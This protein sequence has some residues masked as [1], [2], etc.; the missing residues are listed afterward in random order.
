MSSCAVLLPKADVPPPL[1]ESGV[2]AAILIDP[3]AENKRISAMAI[4]PEQARDWLKRFNAL[5]RRVK[6]K[7]V[8]DLSSAIRDGRWKF[9]HSPVVFDWN[10]A[11]M[12]GQNRLLACIRTGTPIVSDVVFG[13]D[14]GLRPTYDATPRSVVDMLA[15]A[16]HVPA[17]SSYYAAVARMLETA[18]REGI[19]GL[20]EPKRYASKQAI[21]AAIEQGR[22]P[23][24]DRAAS[25]AVRA[26][27]IGCAPRVAGFCWYKFAEQ[28]RETA[29]RFIELF[30]TGLLLAETS[31]VLCLRNRIINS[32]LSFKELI[33][34]FFKA[35]IYFRADRSCTK[36][37]WRTQ[38]SN[39]EAF[40]EI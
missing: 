9:N 19:G 18:R 3:M 10:R 11:L 12:D 23:L 5:N 33:A 4:S 21:N 32:K 14:P 24:L 26:R 27:R 20:W 6:A 15:M 7:D 29:D 34:L 13:L 17:N 16:G 30:L 25:V 39:P 37:Y 8:L 22:F 40:P 38:A 31:P 1:P 36:L 35:W 2:E 28:D